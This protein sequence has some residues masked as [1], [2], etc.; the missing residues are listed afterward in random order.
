MTLLEKIIRGDPL[1]RTR[2]HDLRGNLLDRASWVNLPAAYTS[3]ALKRFG[4]RPKVPWISYRARRLLARTIQPQ[5]HILEFG[6]GASPLWFENRFALVHSIESDPRWFMIV[7][8]QI[9]GRCNVR[10]ECRPLCCYANLDDYQDSSL[11]LSLIDGLLRAACARSVVSKPAAGAIFIWI[12]ATSML[13]RRRCCWTRS[14]S[15][16]AAFATSWILY[17]LTARPAR[18]CLSDWADPL[19]A[20]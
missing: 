19:G 2:F 15:V 20:G 12:T 14:K 1:R 18:A 3:A 8:S 10:Y 17:L 7:S 9:A 13:K 4:H 5:W 11:D 16:T 6:S